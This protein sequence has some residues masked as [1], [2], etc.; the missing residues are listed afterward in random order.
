MLKKKNLNDIDLKLTKHVTNTIS[1]LYRKKTW[2]N[3]DIWNF[4]AEKSIL[5]YISL[6]IDIFRSAMLYYVIVTSYVDRYS[7][8]WYQWKRRPYTILW[9]QTTILL[10]CQFQFTRGG[11]HPLGRC[12]TKKKKKKRTQEDEGLYPPEVFLKLIIVRKIIIVIIV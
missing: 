9:F 10:V 8:F 5:A 6:K 3:S 7:W 2:W 1:L 11:N 12:V 4:L